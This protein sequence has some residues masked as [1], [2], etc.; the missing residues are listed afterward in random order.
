MEDQKMPPRAKRRSLRAMLAAATALAGLMVAPGFVGMASAQQAKPALDVVVI[1][2]TQREENLQKVPISAAA[3][4]QDELEAMFSAGEDVLALSSRVPGLYAES[5][6]GRVAPR[7]YI[8]GLGN[9]DFDLAASQPVSVIMDDVVMENVVLKSTPLF[10]LDR[11]EVY[12]G[13]QGTLFGRNTTAGVVRFTSVKP[14][15]TPEQEA[16]LSWGTANTT[17]AQAAVGGKVSE[18]VSV[19]LSA[20]YQHRDDWI[21]NSSNGRGD[22][23]GA[24]NEFASRLQVLVKPTDRLSM[25]FN[26]HMR[27]LDG[28]AAIFRANVITKGTHELN[29]NYDRDRVTYNGGD[30]NPQAYKGA[31]GSA[32]I[33]YEF[34]NMTLTSITGYESTHGYSRGDIDGGVAGVGPGFIPFDS[35]TTDGL[36]S[37][38]QWTEELRLASKPGDKLSWQTGV[39]YFDGAFNVTTQ[40]PGFPPVTTVRQENTS[41]AVFGQVGYQITDAFTVTGG[42]RYTDDKKDFGVLRY[43]F[44][45][46]PLSTYN[47][48]VSDEHVSWEV[49]AKYDITPDFGV[50]ARVADGFRGPSIQGRDVAFGLQPSVAKSETILSGEVGWKS[51]LLDNTLRLNGAVFTYEVSDMQLTVVG[52]AGNTVQLRNADKGKAYGFEFDAEW[53]PIDNLVFTGGASYTHTKIDDPNL[54]T[55]VCAQCTVTDP[56]VGGFARVNGN[57][58]PNAP[59]WIGDITARYSIPAGA[60]GEFFAFTDWSYQGKTNIFLYQSIEFQ[61]NN[62]FEGGLKLGYAKTNGA[63]ELAV[64]ARNITNEDNIKGAIDFNNNTAFVNDPRVVGI[65][66]RVKH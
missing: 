10:D 22:D 4:P 26:A 64:F 51:Q 48:S 17:S 58:F 14:S 59:Q 32:N 39:Y 56:I 66:L 65:S 27:D 53:A 11:V 15:D 34:D 2:A 8:R 33:A 21:N 47:R 61:T 18:G 36:D 52:G 3:V 29:G 38:H 31:G 35:D 45:T 41:W 37:L 62:Q 23:L 25:L 49:S 30:N 20:L 19:R 40:G 5:S 16:S 7:F 44:A 6:N 63:W 13:P 46:T 12:R 1:T 54:A 50:Y 24:Y 9:T 43:D 42:V 60:D 57:P 28:T 55:G